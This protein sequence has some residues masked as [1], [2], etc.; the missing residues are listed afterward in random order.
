MHE[1]DVFHGHSKRVMLNQ[2][3]VHDRRLY[4]PFAI[5]ECIFEKLEMRLRIIFLTIKIF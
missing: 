4:W 2:Y 1:K 5:C 3:P